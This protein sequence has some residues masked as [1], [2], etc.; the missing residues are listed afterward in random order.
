MENNL[1]AYLIGALVFGVVAGYFVRHF[2]VSRQSASIEQT[3]KRQLEESRSKAN[4]IVLEAQEKSAGIL[5]EIKK[6]EKERKV[7]LDKVEERLMRKEESLEKESSDIREKEKS[8]VVDIE[9]INQ[10]KSYIEQLKKDLS[11][12]LEKIAGLSS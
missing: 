3:T 2:L 8:V 12:Q 4:E 11:L 1:V 7:Q 5:D 10:A 6:E 9:K